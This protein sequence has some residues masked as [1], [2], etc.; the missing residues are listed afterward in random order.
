MRFGACRGRDAGRDIDCK[1]PLPEIVGFPRIEAEH[2]TQRPLQEQQRDDRQRQP[3]GSSN[4]KTDE[5]IEES[6]DAASAD[7]LVDSTTSACHEYSRFSVAVTSL[8]PA[9]ARPLVSKWRLQTVQYLETKLAASTSRF[10]STGVRDRYL[11]SGGWPR[12]MGGMS[13]CGTSIRTLLG[14][15]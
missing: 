12:S 8:T 10:I 6:H 2:R 5:G 13:I 4:Q 1:K 14:S 9:A 11:I 15:I 3:F 7:C